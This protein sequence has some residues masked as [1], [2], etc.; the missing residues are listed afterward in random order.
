[1][2]RPASVSTPRYGVQARRTIAT[3]PGIH[4]CAAR[5]EWPGQDACP[6]ATAQIPS[7]PRHAAAASPSATSADP[8]P[9]AL[10]KARPTKQ[11]VR[12]SPSRHASSPCPRRRPAKPN[13][14]ARSLK[15]RGHW[16]GSCRRRCRSVSAC[17]D[18]PPAAPSNCVAAAPVSPAARL[19]PSILLAMALVPCAAWCTL[20]AISRVAAP[21]SSTA[22]AM[23]S[24][25]FRSS[26]E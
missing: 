4:P 22:E 13:T 2:P 6:F 10:A 19:T 18:N 7:L 1:M 26:G 24:Q 8:P 20:A 14:R 17:F 3:R 9:R 16:R 12:Q 21:C 15:R 23:S 25:Q 11:A 5:M